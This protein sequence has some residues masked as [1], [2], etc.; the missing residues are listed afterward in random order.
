MINLKFAKHLK[1]LRTTNKISQ[2]ELSEYIGIP[3]TTLSDLENDKY[4][5]S[6]SVAK[7]IA[8]YFGKKIDE[9]T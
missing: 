1:L 9:L 8:K 4:E 5:P 3:Q 6:L 7:K 2:R